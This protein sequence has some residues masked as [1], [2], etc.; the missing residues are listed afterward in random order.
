MSLFIS[1]LFSFNFYYKIFSA[2]QFSERNLVLQLESIQEHIEDARG[3]F[4]SVYNSLKSLSDYSMIKSIEESTRGGTCDET[5]IP[6]PGP[7]SAL[8]KYESELFA[9]HLNSVGELKEKMGIEIQ[10]IKTILKNFNPKKDDIEAL[11]E[12]VNQKIGVINRIFREGEIT[13]LPKVLMAHRGTTRMQM[14]SKGQIIS[15]PDSQISQK[16]N[17]II[18]NLNS[19]E[20]LKKVSFFDANNQQQLIER[21]IN[22]LLAIIPF[23]DTKVVST[24]KMSSP[25]DVTQSDVKAIG[26][27][28]LVDFFI[29]FFTILSK[30]PY[31]ARFFSEETIG[32]YQKLTLRRTLKPFIFEGHFYY[33]LIIPNNMR[34]HKLDEIITKFQVDK[35]ITLSG[36]NIDYNDLLFMH[37][38]KL[39]NFKDSS[40]QVYKVNKTKYDTLLAETD[41][42]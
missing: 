42:L 40:F 4:D 41:K 6:T 19:L 11:E 1:V 18:E 26:L 14:E 2:T 17:T 25:T 12:Q 16:I 20:F 31:R 13:L 27:G 36:S 8:R 22:V 15:C 5:Q 10:E 34:N 33:H 35:L 21:T 24:D 37:Q 29:F 28:F 30:D 32:E 9:S 39:K 7:R 38:V 23:T 3:S